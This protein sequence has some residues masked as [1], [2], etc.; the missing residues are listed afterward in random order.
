MGSVA[1]QRIDPEPTRNNIVD[2]TGL[3]VPRGKL[4]EF[5]DLTIVALLQRCSLCGST[6]AFD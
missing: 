3:F 5:F 4:G 6:R 1:V 2:R